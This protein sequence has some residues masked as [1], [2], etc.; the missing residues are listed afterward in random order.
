MITYEELA[1]KFIDKGY[2]MEL[3]YLILPPA[4]FENGRLLGTLEEQ[5]KSYNECIQR[6]YGEDWEYWNAWIDRKCPQY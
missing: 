3:Q 4:P 2:L 1:K 6:V 5:R